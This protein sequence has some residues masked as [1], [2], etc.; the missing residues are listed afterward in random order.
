MDPSSGDRA[1]R[2]Q[3]AALEEE[4]RRVR[5]SNWDESVATQEAAARV[6]LVGEF[7]R[8][9]QAARAAERVR[10]VKEAYERPFR[11]LQ[12]KQTDA[13]TAIATEE[14]CE[15]FVAVRARVFADQLR[16]FTAR[17]VVPADA[18]IADV[19]RRVA[20]R[21]AREAAEL[22]LRERLAAALA[23][24]APR[25]AALLDAG[26]AARHQLVAGEAAVFSL[27]IGVPAAETNARA[28]ILRAE[29]A[30]VVA[31]AFS[32]P[33]ARVAALGAEAGA[34]TELRSAEA[35]ERKAALKAQ[36]ARERAEEAARRAAEE[37]ERRIVARLKQLERDVAAY[38]KKRRDYLDDD[39]ARQAKLVG[40]EESLAVERGVSLALQRKDTEL[41]AFQRD[42]E[43]ARQPQVARETRRWRIAVLEGILGVGATLNHE[44]VARRRDCLLEQGCHPAGSVAGRLHGAATWRPAGLI[45]EARGR[46]MDLF[47]DFPYAVGGVVPA[48][49]E[50]LT[51]PR[52]RQLD[53][54]AAATTPSPK[55]ATAPPTEGRASPSARS[56]RAHG[57]KPLPP[58]QRRGGDAPA[59][60][61]AE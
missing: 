19:R 21:L 45:H 24:V 17:I 10:L 36:R 47:I 20:E 23:S 50:K 12:N 5:H 51:S 15:R 52:R 59:D 44:L 37:E 13:R 46:P 27:G 41:R 58:L 49:S 34:F 16:D 29:A 26:E 55:H 61:G 57:R 32:E 40:L 2:A 33:A 6:V 4:E 53:K 35:A 8:S 38:T 54:V 11:R 1:A 56:A 3:L 9:R 18:A 42:A 31:I 7:E 30:S 28:A 48:I 22:A 25:I 14:L 43:A 39:F 60:K